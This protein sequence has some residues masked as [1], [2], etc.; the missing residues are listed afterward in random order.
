MK[1]IREFLRG[2]SKTYDLFGIQ[3]VSIIPDANSNIEKAWS[4]VGHS[5]YKAI[6]NEKKYSKTNSKHPSKR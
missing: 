2:Y 4:N 6:D 3:S 5:I 1:N